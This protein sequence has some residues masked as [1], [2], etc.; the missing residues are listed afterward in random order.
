MFDPERL[1]VFLDVVEC[2]GFTQA[3]KK[4]GLSK[5]AISKQITA[6]EAECGVQLLARTTRSITLTEAGEGIYQQ[7][8]SVKASLDE[9]QSILKGHKKTPQGLLKVFSGRHFAETYLIPNLPAFLERYPAVILDLELG[10]RVVDFEKEGFDIVVGL[11]LSGPPNAIQKKIATTR[12]ILCASPEYLKCFGMPKSIEDLQKHRYVAHTA[13]RPNY[14]LKLGDKEIVI[15]PF[16]YVN[17]TSVLRKLALEGVGIIWVHEY[18]VAHD[19]KEKKL[20]E[21]LPE[22]SQ[23]GDIP[24]FVCYRQGK[25]TPPKV[26][27]FLDF[28]QSC[29]PS[30][31]N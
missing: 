5:A 9:I 15:K 24:L 19:L 22:L 29:L 26:R 2:G 14:L 13:R 1:L 12:Y 21:A 3:G 17:D 10:E 30:F 16:M 6:F 27:V 23:N 31:K 4:R 7:G 8:L 20:I 25:L 11:S 28:I 18:V